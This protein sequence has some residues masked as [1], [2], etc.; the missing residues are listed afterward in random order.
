[1]KYFTVQVEEKGSMLYTKNPSKEDWLFS[2][3]DEGDMLI[4]KCIEI[5]QETLDNLQEFTGF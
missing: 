1:M 3:A 5:S 2:E 4:I